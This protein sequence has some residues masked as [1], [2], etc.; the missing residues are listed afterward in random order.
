MHYAGGD[1]V[2][3]SDANDTSR[4]S[5]ELVL[6]CNEDVEMNVTRSNYNASTFTY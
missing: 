2:N 4:Y 1:L 6:N 5:F 3:P